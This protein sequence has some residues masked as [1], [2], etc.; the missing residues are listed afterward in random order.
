M[1]VLGRIDELILV[2]LGTIGRYLCIMS[3]PAR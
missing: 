3:S 1:I 2:K